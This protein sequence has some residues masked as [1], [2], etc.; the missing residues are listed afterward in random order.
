MLVL[1]GFIVVVG[2][3]VL[4]YVIH[5]GNLMVL[6]QAGE[7]III[8]G[9]AV[10]VVLAAE[11]PSV[12]RGVVRECMGLLRPSR[13]GPA[14]YMELLQVLYQLFYL[15]RKEGLQGVEAHVEDPE[16][17]QIFQRY[18]SFAEND[19]AVEFLC[20]TF[21]ILLTGAVADHHLS[22]ILDVDLDSHLEEASSVPNALRNVADAMPAFG[23]VAAV[24]GVIIT[25]GKIGGAPEMVGRS[26]AAALVGTFLGIFLGYG[27]FGPLSRAIRGRVREEEQYMA[28][29]RTALLSFSRGDPPITC[30]EFA[31][32]HIEPEMRPSFQ[33]LEEATRRRARDEGAAP[34]VAEAA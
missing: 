6:V 32:R 22:E 3:V 29:I 5:G 9:A 33:D 8:G 1:L 13:Y 12:V 14:V 15:A 28:C 2:S 17:S 30:V 23:I 26:V 16:T 27:V 34:S 19:H 18:P 20:D 31:R 7:Y 25:M 21:K 10:G 24:L 4:G 11:R